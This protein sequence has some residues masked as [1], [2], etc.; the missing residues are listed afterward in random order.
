MPRTAAALARQPCFACA[1]PPS[2][3]GLRCVPRL[4]WRRKG[5]GERVVTGKRANDSQWTGR[6]VATTAAAPVCLR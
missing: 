1:A 3:W 5:K 2:M 4:V 6:R